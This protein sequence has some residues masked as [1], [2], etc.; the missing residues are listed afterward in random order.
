MN[1]EHDAASTLDHARELTAQIPG[2][3]LLTLNGGGHP[4]SFLGSDCVSHAEAT[5]LIE[6][7]LPDLGAR[8]PEPT[9]PFG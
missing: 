6:R 1:S 3:R 2:A 5:A 4:A 7:H 8:C 9:A